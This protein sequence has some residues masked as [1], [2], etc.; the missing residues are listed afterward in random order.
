MDSDKG[1]GVDSCF[2]CG[3]AH[4]TVEYE[5]DWGNP[6]M[7]RVVCLDCGAWV[8]GVTVEKAIEAWN[9]AKTGEVDHA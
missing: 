4:V 2:K 5:V 9:S 6:V 8:S 1:K 7:P 3:G